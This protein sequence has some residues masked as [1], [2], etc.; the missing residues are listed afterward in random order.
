MNKKGRASM[1]QSKRLVS[2]VF[3]PVIIIIITLGCASTSSLRKENRSYNA[4]VRQD[5]IE[6]YTEFIANNPDGVHVE[7]AKKRLVELEWEKTARANTVEAYNSFIRKYKGYPSDSDYIGLAQTNL[8]RLNEQMALNR[9]D[10]KRVKDKGEKASKVTLLKKFKSPKDREAK[11]KLVSFDK[12][13]SQKSDK[14]FL[15]KLNFIDKPKWTNFLIRGWQ[16]ILT[17]FE[18]IYSLIF[19]PQDEEVDRARI[20]RVEE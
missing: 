11:T 10:R 7:D 14:K 1:G 18:Y 5:T 9:S 6:A 16:R 8:R 3:V 17:F 15:T 12:S 20:V 19:N 2:L 13:E 4:A